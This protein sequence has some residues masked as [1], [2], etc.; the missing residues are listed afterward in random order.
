MLSLVDGKSCGQCIDSYCVQCKTGA[1]YFFGYD[2]VPISPLRRLRNQ[3]ALTLNKVAKDLGIDQ[4]HLS[5][6]ETC[7]PTT[8][9]RACAIADYYGVPLDALRETND[10]NAIETA[11]SL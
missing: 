10:A 5:R 9:K 7:G 3:R 6:I 11:T 2:E 4:G 8:W 1:H